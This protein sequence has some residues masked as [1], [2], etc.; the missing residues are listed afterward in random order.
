MDGCSKPGIYWRIVM[1]ISWSAIAAVIIFQFMAS[2]N[3]LVLAL[4]TIDRNDLKPLTLVPLMCSGQFMASWNNV[5]K[6]DRWS[7]VYTSPLI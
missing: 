4:V 1:P 3:A 2:F 5:L 7:C 6:R